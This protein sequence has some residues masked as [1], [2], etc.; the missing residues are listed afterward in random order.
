MLKLEALIQQ[1]LRQT[2]LFDGWSVR[3]ACELQDRRPVPAVDV[4][5][6]GAD[7][8]KAGQ[9][10]VQLQPHWQVSLVV[11]RSDDAA[12]TL[13]AAIEAVI[14]ALHNWRPAEAGRQWSELYLQRVLPVEF[15]ES[16][17]VGFELTFTTS[18]LFHGQP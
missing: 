17:L 11:A 9:R 14:A 15:S 7:V 2:A 10:A 4:R 16:G 13:D 8:P 6:G 12:A 18:S 5:M 1:R 3:G